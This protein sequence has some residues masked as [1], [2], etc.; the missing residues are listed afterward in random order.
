MKDPQ[1]LKAGRVQL[2]YA[3][4]SMAAANSALV[5]PQRDDVT[6]RWD[7]QINGLMGQPVQAE[8]TVRVANEIV[9]ITKAPSGVG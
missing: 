1:Q 4:Q 7:P 5:S 9:L 8:Q 2:D 3:I 6:L